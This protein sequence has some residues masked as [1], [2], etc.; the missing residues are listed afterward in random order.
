[1]PSV[2]LL[3][4]WAALNTFSFGVPLGESS[5]GSLNR[6]ARMGG[7]NLR[8]RALWLARLGNPGHH[9]DNSTPRPL[10]EARRYAYT[11]LNP[12]KLGTV[13]WFQRPFHTGKCESISPSCSRF[14]PVQWAPHCAT[15]TSRDL[16]FG[17]P[18]TLAPSPPR[19][20]CLDTYRHSMFVELG[21]LRDKYLH[22]YYRLPT[23]SLTSRCTSECISPMTA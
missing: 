5:Y 6:G 1:M 10:A 20:G 15:C 22:A 17:T 11:T 18:H 13:A 3:L 21:R 14:R 23:I 16:G 4:S 2:K 7:I 19:I 8:R 12:T 9:R